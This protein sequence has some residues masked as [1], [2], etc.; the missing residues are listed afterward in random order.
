MPGSAYRGASFNTDLAAGKWGL[1]AAKGLDGTGI[2]DMLASNNLSELTDKAAARANL[3]L[4]DVD[5]VVPGSYTNTNLTVDAQGRIDRGGEWDGWRRRIYPRLLPGR[6]RLAL[7][8]ARLTT[9][10]G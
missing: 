1:V 8:T 7:A 4:G 10:P 9:R 6:L 2:G 5:P 3:G